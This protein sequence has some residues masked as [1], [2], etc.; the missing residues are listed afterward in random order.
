M[1]RDFERMISG[2]LYDP[3]KIKGKN[4]SKKGRSLAQKI[5]QTSI[6]DYDKIVA[7]EKEL[8]CTEAKNIYVNPP[9]YVDYGY[10]IKI[11]ENFYANM[12]CIFLD[13]APITIGN[14]VMFGPRVS[15][16]TASHPLDPEVRVRGLECASA[17]N[18]GDN[19]WLGANVTVNPGVSIGKNT[20]I[21]SGSVVTKDIPDNVV[22][23]G[24]PAKVLRKLTQEDKDYWESKE[25]DYHKEKI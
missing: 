7:L 12:D 25:V 5:N 10:N 19:V 20:I 13:V 4:S 24:N 9:L 3:K 1:P 11:G 15:L 6:D 22:A 21:G 17:I 18:I 8:F 23:A 2:D 14:N 16:I